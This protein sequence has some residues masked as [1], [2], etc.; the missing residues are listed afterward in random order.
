MKAKSRERKAI[1][2]TSTSTATPLLSIIFSAIILF[3]VTMET[4]TSHETRNT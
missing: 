2:T 4:S 3:S 1:Y